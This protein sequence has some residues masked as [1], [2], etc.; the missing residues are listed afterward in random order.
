[1]RKNAFFIALTLLVALALPFSLFS[2]SLRGKT[3]QNRVF[4]AFDTICIVWD[5]SGMDSEDFDAL[6]GGIENSA[7]YYHTLFD[8]YREYDAITNIATLNRMAGEGPV[9]VDR[10]I[11]DLLLFSEEMY[12]ATGGRVNYAL[13]AV[14][15]LWKTLPEEEGRIPT[16]SELAEAGAHVSVDS[17]IIDEV[18]STV[19]IVDASLRI[20]VGAIAKG[21]TAE[22]IK[23]DLL[24]LGYGGIVLDFGGNLCSVGQREESAIRN[25]LYPEF[26]RE[27]YVR[28]TEIDNDS[29]VTSGVYER[30]YTVDGVRYHHIIDSETL[31]PET[32]YLSVTVK[33]SDSG[34]ADALSTALF[35]TDYEEVKEF[36]SA[37]DEKI[38][39]TLVFLDGKS[40][41]IEN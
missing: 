30:Y 33:T 5:Y 15:R 25:P 17:V 14:T 8:A 20:D 9:K 38:E 22:L 12:E 21:Y 31:Y 1:M 13:G 36:V 37:F 11:I 34:V 29:I 41:I 6:A 40:E 23:N 32:R 18:A 16:E 7:C 3:P 10:A 28:K 39:I 19:E 35:N 4:D 26:S 2:C 24:S 27:P